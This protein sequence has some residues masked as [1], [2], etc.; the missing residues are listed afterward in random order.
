MSYVSLNYHIVFATK[1]RRPWLNDHLRPQLVAYMGGIIR[2]MKGTLLEANGPADHM[3]LAAT[4]H[5]TACV[6]DFAQEIKVGS[7]KWIHANCRDLATFAWQ[8]GYA[9]FT[10]SRSVM[11]SVIKYI[12]TQQ[13]HH[14]KLTFV[15]ELRLMLEKHDIQFDERYLV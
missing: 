4:I 3:H 10:V 15:Q 12:S 13:E 1:E 2:S 11:P 5:P 7:S 6:S 9:A 8:D 14:E